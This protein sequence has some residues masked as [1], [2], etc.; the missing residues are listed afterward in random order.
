MN[1]QSAMI[2]LSQQHRILRMA[3]TVGVDIIRLRTHGNLYLLR[4]GAECGTM[5]RERRGGVV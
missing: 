3:Q 5:E 2:I 1:T 4:G